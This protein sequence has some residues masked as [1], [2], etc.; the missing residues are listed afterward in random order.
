MQFIFQCCLWW[1]IALRPWS[2]SNDVILNNP[3]FI[4]SDICFKKGSISLR[5]R[6][7]SQALMRFVKWISFNSCGIQISSFSTSPRRCIWRSIV[8]FGIFK[9]LQSLAQLHDNSIPLWLWIG[10]Q[11]L[12][13]A[14][15]IVAHLWVKNSHTEKESMLLVYGTDSYFWS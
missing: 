10:H 15:L 14:E 13:F 5:L 9:F 8:E 2:I 11:K 7:K 3:F 12:H 4:T 1:F 6:W